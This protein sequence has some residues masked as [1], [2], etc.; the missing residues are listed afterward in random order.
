[1]VEHCW[2][3]LPASKEVSI[4]EPIE[5]SVPT[6]ESVDEIT[7]QSLEGISIVTVKFARGVDLGAATNDIRDKLDL[8]ARRLPDNAEKPFIFKFNTSMIP[9]CM[10]SVS[11]DESWESSTR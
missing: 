5:E 2:R 9:V 10:L 7:S 8:V 1:L 3:R 4:T 11:A 6:V